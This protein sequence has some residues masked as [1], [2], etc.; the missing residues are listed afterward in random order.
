[1]E[2][3]KKTY[4]LDTIKSVRKF[5]SR[6]I[7]EYYNQGENDLP[8]TTSISDAKF[9]NLCYSLNGLARVIE[10]GELEKR[11]EALEGKIND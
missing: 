1:M 7:F 10:N 4:R 11:I 2:N 3:P 9:K 6:L 8:F 5:Y